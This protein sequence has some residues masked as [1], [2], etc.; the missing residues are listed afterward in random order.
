MTATDRAT[1]GSQD[2]R[3]ERLAE[4]A[5]DDVLELHPTIATALGDHRFDDRLPDGRPEALERE[6]SV[7]DSRVRELEALDLDGL[8]PDN[9][10][11]G[12]ILLSTLRGRLYELDA[13]REHEWN[14]LLA[15]PAEAVYVLL[16][17]DFAPLGERLRSLA[18]RRWASGCARSPAGSPP[19]PS[20][21]RSRA[22]RCATCRG[23]TWRRPSASSAARP[24]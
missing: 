18:A 21:S 15:N 20:R 23:S 17:R 8:R 14:P 13:L 19:C 22:G 24:H 1:A 4:A 6:H 11:D 9:R 16:A 2:E 5:V 12:E 10:V 3:F 7:L